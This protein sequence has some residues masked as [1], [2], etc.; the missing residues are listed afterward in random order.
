MRY[1]STNQ[2]SP[3][4]GFREALFK[5]LA[6]DKGL[7]LPESIPSFETSFFKNEMTYTELAT[8]MIQ[9]FVSEYISEPKLAEICNTAFT[10]DI[11]LI[12][13]NDNIYLLELF[14]G[15]TMAFK[16]FAARFMARCMEYLLSEKI[17]I[18][19]A[20]S[21]DTG[22]AVAN[23]FLG[24]EGI[25]VVILYPAGR[26]SEI[27]EK[28]LTTYK[29]NI[30]A[31][32]VNGSFDDCQKMVK[33]AFLDKT[34]SRKLNLS[35]ANSINIARL[36][37]QSVY[38]AWAWKHVNSNQPTI[39]SVP[40]G[41]FGNLTGGIF[42][43]HMGLPIQK[44]I[45]A[46]NANNVFPQ[47]L[48]TGKFNSIPSKETI[49]NAMDVGNPS[50]FDR[51]IKIYDENRNDI[52][53]DIIS[54]SFK[55]RT[56]KYIIKSIHNNFN[57]LVDP[58]TAVGISGIEKYKKKI[59][60]DFNY[61]AIATAHPAKFIQVMKPIINKEITIPKQLQ[62]SMEKEKNSIR[63]PASCSSLKDFLI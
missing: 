52:Q 30:T 12:C 61:I 21:G 57:Y 2:K 56:T 11:P 8:E 34:L 38:Y 13:L 46:T 37:P 50:N 58:H 40:S 15:P 17:T 32:E 22:G 29:G 26:V 27:Q 54:W 47:Y 16:D 18:L 4:V 31:L 44:F 39:F 60:T 19:V 5:G 23:G 9:P 35:S 25:N 63:I 10:F 62:K 45:A 24:L 33:D 7:Y 59:N 51:I 1:Y 42:A 28:Q 41:N 14:H 36:L 6:P 49:S 20:T 3:S 48:K 55:D 53:N 43:K